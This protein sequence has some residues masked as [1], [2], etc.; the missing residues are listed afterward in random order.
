MTI[1]TIYFTN[2]T[3]KNIVNS[4]RVMANDLATEC[5]NL[6][7]EGWDILEITELKIWD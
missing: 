4:V 6:I 5:N 7:R 2:K 3:L 1:Y